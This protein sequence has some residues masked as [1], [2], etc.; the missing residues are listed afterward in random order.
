MAMTKWLVFAILIAALL[1][2]GREMLDE[3]ARDVS[4]ALRETEAGKASPN[5]RGAEFDKKYAAL[6]NSR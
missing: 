3:M 6:K 5:P 2:A 1:P 4:G